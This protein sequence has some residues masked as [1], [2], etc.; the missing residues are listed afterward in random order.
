ML[1]YKLNFNVVCCHIN[2]IKCV[3]AVGLITVWHEATVTKIHFLWPSRNWSNSSDSNGS[4]SSSLSC[5]Q[6]KLFWRPLLGRTGLFSCSLD[7]YSLSVFILKSSLDRPETF[8][9]TLTQSQQVFLGVTSVWFPCSLLR[10]I[11][12]PSNHP[13]YIQHVQTTLTYPSLSPCCQ[14]T[15][16]VFIF[17][18]LLV[19][20]FAIV[21]VE[22]S[23]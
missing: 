10:Y 14:V 8:I 7:S 18:V 22:V 13:R 21:T 9:S 6:Y 19:V 23:K 4:S 5:A 12:C 17:A 3:D 2:W 16:P 15:I 11:A 1:P 20:V